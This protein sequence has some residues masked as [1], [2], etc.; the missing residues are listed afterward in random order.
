[1]KKYLLVKGSIGEVHSE[2]G[3]LNVDERIGTS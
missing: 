3:L 1:M 2:C